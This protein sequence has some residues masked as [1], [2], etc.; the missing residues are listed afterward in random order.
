MEFIFN[1]VGYILW[2][3]NLQIESDNRSVENGA[4]GI[5]NWT[6]FKKWN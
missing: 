4:F 3:E 1:I 6:D 2:S 5:E